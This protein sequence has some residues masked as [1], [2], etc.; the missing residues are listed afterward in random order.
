MEMAPIDENSSR[1]FMIRHGEVENHD[2]GVFNGQLDVDIT[3]RGVGHM[4]RAAEFLAAAGGER[5]ETGVRRLYSSD[6]LRT[7]RGAAIISERLGLNETAQAVPDIR[8]IHL[9]EWQGLSFEEVD[10]RFPGL[11][12][13]RHADIVNYRIPGSETV[14]ELSA[15]VVPAVQ[16]IAGRHRGES[17]AI[18]AHAGPNR[19]VLCHTLGVPLKRVFHIQQD[20]GAINVLD[21]S[22]EGAVVR[23]MN[24]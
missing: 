5:G 10:D 22:A 19:M 23:L 3:P 14:A 18:V 9:G 1:I 16:E 17:V 7:V 20:Y 15:R 6:L 11:R 24:G 21:F 4:E 12:E 13:T 2:R 8:E